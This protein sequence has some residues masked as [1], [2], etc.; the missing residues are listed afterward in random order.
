[1]FALAANLLLV[2]IASM[3]A[4]RMPQFVLSPW[5]VFLVAPAG[6]GILTLLYVRR[7]GAMH[8][9]L[10]SIIAA[11]IATAFVFQG[12]WQFAVYMVAASTL[13]A[14]VAEMVSIWRENRQV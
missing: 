10:G 2:T 6:A 11:P 5:L 14:S 9:F 1:M 13:G 7:R 8:A 4:E 12:L 3:M